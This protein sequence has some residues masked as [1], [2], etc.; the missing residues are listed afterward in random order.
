MPGFFTTCKRKERSLSALAWSIAQ[1]ARRFALRDW[2]SR[3][4]GWRA[5]E[6]FNLSRLRP[7]RSSRQ[8]TCLVDKAYPFG[9]LVDMA[10]VLTADGCFNFKPVL[11][12]L[13]LQGGAGETQELGGTGS[14]A[15]RQVEGL[16]D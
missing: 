2:K 5:R 11:F 7:A 10:V 12:Y 15:A 6:A 1:S 9:C 3:E 13:R 14:I 4:T 16:T 8:E